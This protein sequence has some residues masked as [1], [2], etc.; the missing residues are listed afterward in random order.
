MLL[1]PTQQAEVLMLPEL[2]ESQLHQP[3]HF[4]REEPRLLSS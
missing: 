3:Q 1:C 2:L 4:G